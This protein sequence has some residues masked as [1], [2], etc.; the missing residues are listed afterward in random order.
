MDEIILNDLPADHI[1]RNTKLEGM[2][3]RQKG[4]K[5]WKLI[6]SNYGIKNVTFNQLNADVWIKSTEFAWIQDDN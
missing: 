5:Y 2:Y 4:S 6:N 3:H 1:L